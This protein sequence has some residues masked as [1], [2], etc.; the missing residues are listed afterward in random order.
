MSSSS[1]IVCY[2]RWSPKRDPDF[3]ILLFGAVE[4]DDAMRVVFTHTTGSD[5]AR[6]E[7]LFQAPSGNTR[8]TKTPIEADELSG[9]FTYYELTINQPT[10]QAYAITLEGFDKCGQ[11]LSGLQQTQ[12]PV[13]TLTDKTLNWNPFSLWSE[14][15]S[16]EQNILMNESRSTWNNIKTTS[17]SNNSYNT[18]AIEVNDYTCFRISKEKPGTPNNTPLFHYPSDLTH[19]SN[20]VCRTGSLTAFLPTAISLG[21]QNNRLYVVGNGIDRDKSTLIVFNRWGEQIFR[22]NLNESWNPEPNILP[23][24]YFYQATVWGFNGEKKNMQGPIYIIE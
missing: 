2:K 9:A 16:P 1:N 17:F 3:Q 23:G 20:V 8:F 12:N 7:L 18:E 21:G 10:H 24:V 4:A 6:S 19:Y 11:A 22:A 5:I 13:L 15:I 14:S